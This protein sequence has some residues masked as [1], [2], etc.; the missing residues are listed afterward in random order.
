VAF[1]F[2]PSPEGNFTNATIATS[3]AH[4]DLK[5]KRPIHSEL[6]ARVK[7]IDVARNSTPTVNAATSG[8][9]P[10]HIESW[11]IDSGA[12]EDLIPENMAS[13]EMTEMAENTITF[14]TANGTVAN[15]TQCA[16][17]C[18]GLTLNL[19]ARIL[20]NTPAVQSLGKRCM[21]DGFTFVWNKFQLPF[22]IT[23]KGVI[24]YL[25]V[26]NN[27]PYFIDDG[28]NN[29]IK[30]ITNR[31]T[32]LPG[33]PANPEIE[34]LA[35]VD[36]EEGNLT[37]YRK[38]TAEYA[39]TTEHMMTHEPKNPFCRI[40]QIAK[41]QRQSAK[42]V[43]FAHDGQHP[44]RDAKEFGDYI[45]IDHMINVAKRNDEKSEDLNDGLVCLDRAT[46]W[47]EVYPTTNKS[48][49]ETISALNDF[50]GGNTIKHLYSDNAPELVAAGEEVAQTHSFSTPG[51]SESNGVAERHLRIAAEGGRAALTQSGLPNVWWNFAVRHF[52][53]S[54]NRAHINGTSSFERRHG[55]PFNGHS[56]PFGA[57]VDYM[58][59]PR[60][61]GQTHTFA[62]KTRPGVFLGYRVQ[63]GGKCRNEYICVDLATLRAN[64]FQPGLRREGIITTKEIIWVPNQDI[65]FIVTEEYSK[66]NTLK[67]I[68]PAETQQ[69]ETAPNV[70]GD[71]NVALIPDAEITPDSSNEGASS[72]SG[73]QPLTVY[74]RELNDVKRYPMMGSG[75]SH[76]WEHCV[77]RDTYDATTNVL[78]DRE[79]NV[80]GISSSRLK[81]PLPQGTVNIRVDFF[82]RLPERKEPANEEEQMIRDAED[83]NGGRPLKPS[84]ARPPGIHPDVW[85]VATNKERRTESKIHKANLRIAQNS[86]KQETAQEHEDHPAMPV[87]N[88]TSN[89]E[90]GESHRQKCLLPLIPMDP[91]NERVVIV[92]N[93]RLAVI[94]RPVTKAEVANTTKAQEALIKE[95]DRLRALNTWDETMVREYKDVAQEAKSRNVETHFCRLFPICVEKG[96]ELPEGDPGRKFKG[97]VVLQ[98]NNVRTENADLAL[99]G[100]LSSSPASME[101]AKLADTV[102][103]FP[104]YTCQ[105]ADA[106]QAY[107]QEKFRG[108]PTWVEVPREYWPAKWK[109]QGYRRPVCPLRLALYGHPDSGAYWEQYCEKQILKAGF[110]PVKNWRSTYFDESR[111]AILVI[112]V[113]DFKL[114][115]P[116]KLIDGI[117]A[118]LKKNLNLDTPIPSGK[119]LGC[120]HKITRCISETNGTLNVIEYDMEGFL[121]A[122]VDRYC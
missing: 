77:R 90:N 50:T 81:R 87:T 101:A 41:A 113:D 57:L 109:T 94:A 45:T 4:P 96:Y 55:I 82:L 17:Q 27:V 20:P 85:K 118:E 58:P 61:L 75:E 103:L 91:F 47:I 63:P 69:Q 92:N 23:P 32:F 56:I 59:P 121:N 53:F 6:Q 8:I 28:S 33:V 119:Y 73:L 38:R 68:P 49:R 46:R 105:I 13:P 60:V 43:R 22:M 122:C 52:C 11:I 48:A 66:D 26:R 18:V 120:D 16:K 12:G 116:I 76:L 114:S 5:D 83:A 64:K 86:A 80:H 15:N 54:R 102:G 108:K 35:D 24:E 71:E 98:G 79:D 67:P 42:A 44:E 72:G 65:R 115:A 51:R 62:A 29:G 74:T 14:T 84:S 39:K 97:R 107:T 7:A 9:D 89:D 34:P 112:Y 36:A 19:M 1:P 95:W 88:K 25:P 110:K 3:K 21:E 31:T 30:M 106:P 111:K 117:W 99:F 2:S 104:E 70:I 93:E 78:I 100:E 10:Y 40:C 37:T